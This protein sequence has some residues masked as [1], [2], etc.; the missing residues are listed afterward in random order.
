M[1]DTYTKFMDLSSTTVKEVENEYY[2]YF[3][4]TVGC[5]CALWGIWI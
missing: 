2:Y 4:H 5:H 1:F 3:D